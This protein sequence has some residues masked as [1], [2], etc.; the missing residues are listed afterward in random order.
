MR[1]CKA[2]QI[3]IADPVHRCPL[4]EGI[5][6]AH[7]IEREVGIGDRY[8]DLEM[9]KGIYQL[10]KRIY[11]FVSILLVGASVI[12]DLSID[13]GIVWSIISLGAVM[14]SWTVVYHAIKSNTSVAAKIL[15]Q[16]I[17]GSFFIYLID[18]VVGYMGWS[19]NFVIP[20]IFILANVTIVILMLVNRMAFKEYVF[21]QLATTCIGLIPIVLIITDV[22][23]HPLLSY[24]CIGISSVILLGTIIFG[25]KTV[26][27]ELIRRFH[28]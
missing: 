28:I 1:Y 24:I 11:L 10:I 27:D 22:V 26:K 12:V 2:C 4:C 25:D 3:Q 19:V 21:Y 23:V 15:V 14:Y 9:Q 20:Q 6:E 17:A 8:P 18:R 5:L 13:D 16:A 7:Q